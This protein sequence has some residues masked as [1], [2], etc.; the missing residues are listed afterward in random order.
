M[1]KQGK[2]ASYKSASIKKK[3]VTHPL[4]VESEAK[5]AAVQDV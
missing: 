2:R 1:L 5:Y 3:G 4:K